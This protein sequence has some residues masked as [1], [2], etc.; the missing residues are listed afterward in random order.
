MSSGMRQV[1]ESL[2]LKD[3]AYKVDGLDSRKSQKVALYFSLDK[4][5]FGAGLAKDEEM[6][7]HY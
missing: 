2:L 4:S 1:A 5:S 7:V 3:A 6:F